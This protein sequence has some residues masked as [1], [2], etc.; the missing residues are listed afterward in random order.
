MRTVAVMIG[1][2]SVAALCGCSKP[3]T[4]GAPQAPKAELPA[5]TLGGVLRPSRRAGLWRM[6]ISMRQG[7]GFSLNGEMC[8]DAKTDTADSFMA[9][10]RSRA[11]SHCDKAEFHPAPG[12]GFQFSSRCKVDQRTINTQGLIKGDFQ[13]T[14]SVDLTTRTDPPVAGGPGEIKT[15][16]R[17]DVGRSLSAGR[18]AGANEDER[19]EPRRLTAALR[20]RPALR[21]APAPSA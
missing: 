11:A 7:P 5:S 4:P 6:K 16:D 13:T 17:G 8:L 21:P 9:N 18:L 15:S 14:Y 19:C 12:G 3:A 2:V 1:L 10:A 20:P